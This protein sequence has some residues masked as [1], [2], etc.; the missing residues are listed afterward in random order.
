MSDLVQLGQRGRTAQVSEY[1]GK[2][3][4]HIRE[5]FWCTSS[6]EFKATKRG[7]TLNYSE[8]T[9]LRKAML[10]FDG[11]FKKLEKKGL[12]L[13]KNADRYQPYLKGGRRHTQEENHDNEINY[14]AAEQFE[15]NYQDGKAAM[16]WNNNGEYVNHEADALN[17]AENY[18]TNYII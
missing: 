13:V 18:E 2:P 8:F 17:Y 3:L 5:Y 6:Q 14:E 16:E 7:P 11:E 9:K 12:K 15:N 1:R 10:Y 4:F